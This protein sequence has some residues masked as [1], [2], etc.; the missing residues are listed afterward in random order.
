MARHIG[1]KVG[2]QSSKA[3]PYSNKP[4]SGSMTVK[5]LDP[6]NSQAGNTG[7]PNPQKMFRP[8][9]PSKSPTPRKTTV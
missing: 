4:K 5:N 3:G 8:L 9:A 1:K 6:K 7:T 2:K